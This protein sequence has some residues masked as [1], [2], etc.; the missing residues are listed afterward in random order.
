MIICVSENINSDDSSFVLNLTTFLEYWTRD[1][2]SLLQ[3]G[4]KYREGLDKP[5]SSWLIN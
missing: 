4:F 2:T 1:W 3:A 5:P